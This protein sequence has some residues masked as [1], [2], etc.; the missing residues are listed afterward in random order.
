MQTHDADQIRTSLANNLLLILLDYVYKWDVANN[1]RRRFGNLT[2]LLSRTAIGIVGG[3]SLMVPLIIMTYVTDI[4]Y[5]LVIVN[6]ATIA[7]AVGLAFTRVEGYSVVVGTAAYASIMAVYVG[8]SA[9]SQ[10]G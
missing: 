8:S 1:L 10:T 2:Q 5:R 6:L 7:F 4:N 9:S 3:A